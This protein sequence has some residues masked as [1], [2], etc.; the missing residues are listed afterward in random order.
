ML[1]SLLVPGFGEAQASLAAVAIGWMIWL[2]PLTVLAGVL[3][4]YL[5]AKN[6]FA[7]EALG[8][9]IINST[10]IVGLLL[11]HNGYGTMYLLLCLYYFVACYVC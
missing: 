7:I 9:L 11:V 10:I 5:H 2:I 8:T 4:A 6:Q 1:V 3:T